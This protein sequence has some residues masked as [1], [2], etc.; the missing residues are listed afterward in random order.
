M[1]QIALDLSQKSEGFAE[2]VGNSQRPKVPLIQTSRAR[3]A[4][5]TCSR[6]LL[7][8]SWS[9][10]SLFLRSRSLAVDFVLVLRE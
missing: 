6:L 3:D 10:V 1:R 2:G 4:A 9:F 8:V 7:E 5:L